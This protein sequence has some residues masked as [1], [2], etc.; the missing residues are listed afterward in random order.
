MTEKGRLIRIHQFVEFVAKA[1]SPSRHA[2]ERERTSRYNSHIPGPMRAISGHHLPSCVE[3]P[4]TPPTTTRRGPPP[5]AEISPHKPASRE[6]SPARNA[7]PT[8]SRKSE[9]MN[10]P[11]AASDSS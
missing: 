10:S 4:V 3:S 9:P 11:G 2:F 7:P 6:K 1:F 8:R 5:P